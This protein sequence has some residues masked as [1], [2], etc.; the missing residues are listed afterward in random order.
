MRHGAICKRGS[1]RCSLSVHRFVQ[2]QGAT[3]ARIGFVEEV[4]PP[5]AEWAGK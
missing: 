2:R 3:G 1:R 5:I 4:K